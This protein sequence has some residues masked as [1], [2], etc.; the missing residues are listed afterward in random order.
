MGAKIRAHPSMRPCQVKATIRVGYSASIG[1]VRPMILRRIPGQFLAIVTLGLFTTLRLF[2]VP[3][4]SATLTA[5]STPAVRINEVL[6]SNTR[7]PNGG[8]FPDIIELFNAG[9]AAVDLSGKRLTDAT[10]TTPY[11]FPSGTSIGPGAYL[12]VYADSETTAPG[13]HLGFN[14]D[15]EGDEVRLLDSTANGGAVLDSIK[16]GFQVP[17]FSVSR[18]GAGANVW[19]LTTPTPAAANGAASAL[20]S[21]PTLRINEWAGNIVFRLDHDMIELYNPTATPMA[22][23]GVRL[24]DDVAVGK[25]FT[26]PP[27]SF[28]PTAG[29]LPL[30]KGDY[31]FGLNG[32]RAVVTLLGENNEQIDQI[33]LIAQPDDR[34]SG[35]S[36]DGS[37]NILQAFTVPTPGISNTTPLP[38][39]YTALLNNLRITEIM[40]EP[41]AP[42]NS[43]DFEY[44]ELQNIGTTT[45]DLNG[46]R[47]TNGI[48]HTFQAGETLAPGAFM[49][50]VNDRSSFLS[51]Y[52]A[53]ASIMARGGFNGSL[54]NGGDT[55]ALTL[56]APWKVHILRFRYDDTWF[57]SASGGGRSLV[58]PTPATTPA[59][60]WGERNA[61]R[62]SAAINGSP[63]AADAGAPSTS[64]GGAT[65]TSRLINLSILTSI[66]TAG[67]TFTMGYVV[68]GAGT[69]GTKSILIRAAGPSLTQL[70][71]TGVLA[72]PRLEF[73][74][75]ATKTG[76]NDN[77]GGTAALSTAFSAVGAFAYAT[78]VSLDAAALANIPPGDNSVRVS[79]TA[80]TG[81]VIAELYDSTPGSSFTAS[82][83]RL[84]NVSVLKHLGS[85]LT[86]G[87]VVGGTGAK[88][89]LIRAVGPTIGAAPFNVS[90]AIADPQLTL[91]SGQTIIATNDNWGGT[92]A[93]TAAF[94]QVG[95]FALPAASRDAAVLATLQPGNYTVQASG[96]GGTTGVAIVEVYEVP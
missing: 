67:D 93:L 72:D 1:L 62:A 75:G 51:R 38:A 86:A 4:S 89:V 37:A 66:A 41:A 90:G 61:W 74:A 56:P 77:W 79:A 29:F 54:N 36:P 53:L 58:I 14:L 87:F 59:A 85:G 82:T 3:T 27:L 18:T 81:T 65:I 17:D 11:T 28:I 76:E 42:N 7:I 39:S 78:P 22:I 8:T 63:G 16:F 35:R 88:T 15:A 83:P 57:E 9:S 84:V 71:V 6:A 25:G 80:G 5:T 95:A 47:F 24:T 92:A 64:G 68:G 32:D 55:I 2:A 26:F 48:E 69:V 96:V 34:S 33:T 46:V 70:G 31:L 21:L 50:V 44:I 30:Y 23:G 52:P 40:Y 49:V 45:L 10:A 94:S 60:N 19:A 13:L 43:S 12:V 91:Y 20:G 73:F